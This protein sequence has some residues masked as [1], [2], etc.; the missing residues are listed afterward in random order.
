MSIKDASNAISVVRVL[1]QPGEP[2]SLISAVEHS[3]SSVVSI[4]EVISIKEISSVTGQQIT[5]TNDIK[6]IKADE[7][8]VYIAAI[9]K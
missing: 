8:K 9:T 4:Q 2:M 1:E 6:V 3:P 7:N 5:L